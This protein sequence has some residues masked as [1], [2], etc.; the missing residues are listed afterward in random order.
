MKG[1]SH[2]EEVVVRYLLGDLPEETQVQ[3]E[4]R[5]FSDP[6]YLRLVEAVETD[7]IDAYVREQLPGA[8]RRQFE[9]RFFASAERRRKVQFARAW[10]R[11]AD[12]AANEAATEARAASGQT[13]AGERADRRSFWRDWFGVRPAAAFRFAMATAAIILVAVASWQVLQTSKLRGRIAELEAEHTRQQQQERVLKNSL[14]AER[15]RVEDLNTQ[16]QRGAQAGVASLILLPG[17]PRDQTVRPQIVLPPSAQLTRLE[18]QLEPRDRYPQFRAQLRTQ[19]GDEVLTRSGL[20][21]RQ[22]NGGRAVVLEVP[23]EALRNGDYELTLQGGHS[24][25]K[26]E[27]IGYYHFSVRK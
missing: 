20:H 18:I 9:S 27:D 8:E 5:A 16:L 11:V 3:I 22:A 12:E 2:E 6:E 21:E 14:D 4:D 26:F 7:L 15:A 19:S 13:V 17:V 1:A 23:V 10:A 25:S 24:G